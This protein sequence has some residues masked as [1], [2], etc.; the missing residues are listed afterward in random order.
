MARITEIIQLD[1]DDSNVRLN[2]H[3]ALKVQRML[4]ASGGG[5]VQ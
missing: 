1:M 2:L 3:L 5:S 4:D